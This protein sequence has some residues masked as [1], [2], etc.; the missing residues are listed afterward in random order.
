MTKSNDTT[1][2]SRK[3]GRVYSEEGM[4]KLKDGG[5]KGHQLSEEA[6]EEKIGQRY[7]IRTPLTR[8]A[9][10]VVRSIKG[11]IP[12]ALFVS[13]AIMHE[14]ERRAQQKGE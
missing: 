5:M 11:L 3:D 4:M 2:R 10:S 13:N 6:L 12:R 14:V 9:L 1:I 7:R 8:Q